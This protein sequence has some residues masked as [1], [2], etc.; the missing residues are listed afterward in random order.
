MERSIE[1][2]EGQS[3]ADVLFCMFKSTNAGPSSFPVRGNF[4]RESNSSSAIQHF[5]IN[6]TLHDV[7]INVMSLLYV[8][9]GREPL[10]GHGNTSEWA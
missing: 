9:R 5:L 10:F 3:R 2:N 6:E 4:C 8:K 7:E 1:P